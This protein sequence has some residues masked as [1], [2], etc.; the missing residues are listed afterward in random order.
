MHTCGEGKVGMPFNLQRGGLLQ[1]NRGISGVDRHTVGDRVGE[2]DVEWHEILD[3]GFWNTGDLICSQ[4]IVTQRF[5]EIELFEM[6]LLFLCFAVTLF[7][8]FQVSLRAL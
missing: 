1:R 4:I 5:T 6:F 3:F 7:L 2:I 8:Y